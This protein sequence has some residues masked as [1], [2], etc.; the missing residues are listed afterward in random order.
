MSDVRLALKRDL[1]ELARTLASAFSEDPVMTWMFEDAEARPEHLLRMQN[2]GLATALLRGHV[3]TLPDL[4]AAALWAPPDVPML[5]D[6]AGREMGR[7]MAEAIGEKAGEKLGAMAQL[8]KAH[9][10]ETHFYLFTLGTHADAQS[11][12]LG[13]RVIAPVLERC[14][15]EGLPAFLESSNPRNVP[16][17]ERHGFRVVEEIVL[18]E[19]G[20][21]MHP[22]WRDPR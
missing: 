21:I 15:A 11:Q 13:S 14:D 7:V 5:D 16:F 9:P 8:Q 1:P 3:Y 10:D 2:F 6:A 4:R 17:Y 18:E 22:M 20:P 19:G 12:G